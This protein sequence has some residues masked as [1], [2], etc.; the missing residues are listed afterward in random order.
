MTAESEASESSSP[1]AEEA[2]VVPLQPL[3]VLPAILLLLGML[4]TRL[5]PVVI[6]DGPMLFWMV[7]AFGP[8]VLGL[9]LLVWWVTF[10]RA[11]AVERVIGLAGALSAFGIS[12]LALDPSMMGPGLL[13]LTGPMGL[14]AFGIG[15]VVLGRG[16]TINRTFIIVLLTAAG[17]GF[18]T[19]LRTEGMWGNFA[20]TTKWRWDTSAEQQLLSDIENRMEGDIGRFSDADVDAW[21]AN[22]EWSSFRGTDGNGVESAGR[23]EDDWGWAP[24]QELWTVS[25]GPGWSSFAV[26]GRLLFTQEQRGPEEA[27]VC[28][29]AATGRELWHQQIESRFSDPLGGPGPRATPT[30][31]GDGLYVQGANGQVLCLDA[32]SGDIVWH[33]DLRELADRDP[34][35]WGFSSSPLVVGSVVVVYAGGKGDLGVFGLKTDTGEVVWS[36]ATG[37]HSYSSPQLCR[38]LGEEL[39]GMLTNQGISLLDPETGES[40]LDYDWKSEAHRALQPHVIGGRSL[41]LPT[42]MG[43]GTRRIDISRSEGRLV[44]T[45]AWTSRK[46]KPDFNDFVI[47]DGCLYGFDGSIVCCIDL[48]TGKQNWKGGRY[49]KGQILL[50]KRS[51][52]LLVLGEFGDIVLLRADP[53][54]HQELAKIK[55]LEGKT[56]NHPVVTGDRLYIRNSEQASCWKLPIAKSESAETAQR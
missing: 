11:S 19:L 56:W 18:S 20:M 46:L 8:L 30:L 1:Q 53:T 23:I 33:A 12:W 9:L 7:A 37:D 35:E 44:A 47:H 45:E 22:P 38:I 13:L 39:V 16:Q 14:A 29:D 26:A 24:P 4:V 6:E 10:S 54:E 2:P 15:A 25:V 21:L 36:A 52:L 43:A 40:R 17:F 41:L 51:G 27:V 5:L 42:G 50:L 31:A 28:Y 55:A 34:P 48:E 3:R 49:G 32:R